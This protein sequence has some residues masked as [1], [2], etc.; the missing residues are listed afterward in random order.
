MVMKNSD[1]EVKNPGSTEEFVEAMAFWFDQK[2]AEFEA[3]FPRTQPNPNASYGLPIRTE[4][5]AA[6]GAAATPEAVARVHDV[7]PP[8]PK[9]L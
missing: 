8:A 5:S 2:S 3:K 6:L 1:N 7:A 9:D 4:T